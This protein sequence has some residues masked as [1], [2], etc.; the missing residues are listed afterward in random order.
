VLLLEAAVEVVEAGVVPAA[1]ALVEVDPAAE[2][3][4][5]AVPAECAWAAE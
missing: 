4:A 1:A 5:W 3:P 2:A